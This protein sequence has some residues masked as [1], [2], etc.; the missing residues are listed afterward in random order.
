MQKSFFSDKIDLNI[1]LDPSTS[2]PLYSEQEKILELV[3][4]Y[5]PLPYSI[6]EFG[7]GKKCSLIIK[8]L[9]DLG[10]PAYALE[11]GMIIERDLSPEALRQT[12]PQKRPLRPRRR[13]G[14]R[15]R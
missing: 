4:N 1:E 10:I 15:W 12:N 2:F 3:M 8:K 11:R 14:L 13:T 5:L 9:I 6:S 7:C